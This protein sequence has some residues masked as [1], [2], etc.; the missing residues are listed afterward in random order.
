MKKIFV[1]VLII[2]VVIGLGTASYF[3]F[4]IK[5]NADQNP[6]RQAIF[7]TNGQVYFGQL[8]SQDKD[9]ITIKDIYYLK[10]QDQLDGSTATEDK[11]I[12]L[13]KLGEELHGPED[14]MRINI[15]QV[16]YYEDMKDDSKINEAIKSFIA[17]NKN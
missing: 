17:K 10:T 2:L 7:L 8:V 15:G 4:K 16:V 5:A 11:K 12:A 13:I 1:I 3:L 14:I 9:F 6:R